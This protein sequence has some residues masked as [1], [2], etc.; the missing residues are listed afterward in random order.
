M[1]SFSTADL[2]T[3]RPL[4]FDIKRH[5]LEDGPGIRSTVFFKGCPLTCLW[6]QNPESIDPG[7]EIGFYPRDCIKC[8]DCVSACPAK[9]C[10]L[11]DPFLIDR[12]RCTRCGACVEACPG[13]ALRLIGRFYPVAELAEILLRDKTFYEVSRGGVTL[14]GGEPTFFMDYASAVLKVLKD[15]GIHTAIQTNGFFSWKEFE[16]KILPYVDLI[17]FDVKLADA[18]KHRE[19]T[20]R[21]NEPIL[22]NLKNLLAERAE[23]VLPRIPLIPAFTATVKNLRSI[24]GLLKGLGVKKCSLL[25]YNPTWTFKAEAIGKKVDPR[26]SSRLLT[27]GKLKKYRDIFSWAELVRF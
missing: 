16:E 2:T 21:S 4:V 6:C 20:G 10:A 14:S 15:S 26:I 11:E 5:A 23:V 17:M 18:D 9:A 3:A 22:A 27:P 24:S 19:Y 8:G 7:P 13:R 1:T 12:E 25:P